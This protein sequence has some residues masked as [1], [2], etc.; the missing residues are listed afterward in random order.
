LTATATDNVG[1]QDTDTL[2][3]TVVDTTPPTVNCGSADG[4]WHNA[5]V[6]ISCTASDGASGLADPTNDAS[7]SL[8]TNVAGGAEDSNATTD[9]RLVCDVAENCELA[10]PVAGNKVDRKAP[11]NIQF[12]G[13]PTAGGAYYFGSVPAAPTCTA[14]DGGSGV[15]SCVVTGYSAAVGVHT[16]TATATDNVGNQSTATRTYS[17]L[18]WST[19]GFYQPVDMGTVL[20]TVKAGSTVPLK[21]EVF[22][23]S[24]E[25]SDPSIVK[26]LTV[27]KINMSTSTLTD[28]IETTATGGTSLRYDSTSGQ[29]I[30]NWST[31]GLLA[32][33]CYQ[34]T[35]TLQ[36]GSTIV[37]YFKMK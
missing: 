5:N 3:Y 4:T 33:Q 32:G 8:T 1:N 16:L 28:E 15:D 20:N 2:T 22:A 27:A 35:L 23:G 37:A 21:F 17:V 36:D 6:S 18:S 25:L 10:G 13:G 26:S 19:K 9:S 7:F 30:Y 34:I 31:K 14:S 11:T 12:V 24:T 29:F